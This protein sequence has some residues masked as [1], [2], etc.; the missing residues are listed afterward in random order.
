MSPGAIAIATPRGSHR[1]RDQRAYDTITMADLDRRSSSIA[2]GLQSMGVVPGK[3]IALLVRFSEDFIALVFAVLKSGATLVLIDP[4][5]GRKNLVDCRRQR[6]MA[7]LPFP[8]PTQY[9]V[10]SSRDFPRRS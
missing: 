3:R 1:Q 2:A 5:M 9:C 4:G 8:S 6:R 7:L 10:A